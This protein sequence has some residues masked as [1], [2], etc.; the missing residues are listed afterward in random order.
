MLVL[1][2][3]GVGMQLDGAVALVTGGGRGIGRQAAIAL[4]RAG[5]RVAVTARSQDQLDTTAEQIVAAGG[6]EAL[7]V[8]GDV[9]SPEDVARTVEQTERRLGPIDVLVNSAGTV[10][11]DPGPVGITDPDDWWQVM[12][13]N[14]R[15]PMLFASRI[16]PGMIERGRGR[17]INLNSLA[18]VDAR[19]AGTG[20]AY[21][22]SKAALF[23]LTDIL[24]AEVAGTGVVVLD[25]SPGLVRTSMTE[26]APAFAEIPEAEWTDIQ[27]AAELIMQAASGR[28]DALTG[29]FVH[30]I[31]DLDTLTRHLEQILDTG[32][33]TLTLRPYGND[34]PLGA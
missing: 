25:I 1:A 11:S 14:V 26:D 20:S 31:D 18:G 4:G 7:A 32:G 8:T 30:V 3:A 24:A 6:P 23:R 9:R 5:C 27:D 34:D 12:E 13:V 2:G 15:G 10:P 21:G 16:V 17:I 33:R 22:V 29:R 19:T 28:L